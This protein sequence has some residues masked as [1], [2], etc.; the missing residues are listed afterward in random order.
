[1]RLAGGIVDFAVHSDIIH[2]EMVVK[3][4][5]SASNMTSRAPGDDIFHKVTAIQ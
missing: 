5:V 2:Q 3:G 4:D 1:M